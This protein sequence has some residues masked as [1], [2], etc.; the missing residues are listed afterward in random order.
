MLHLLLWTLYGHLEEATQQPQQFAA[1]AQ[2][3][4]PKALSQPWLFQPACTELFTITNLSDLYM[5]LQPLPPWPEE[6]HVPWWPNRW[7]VIGANTVFHLH[8][9]LHQ[10]WCRH[11][12]HTPFLVVYTGWLAHFVSQPG[13]TPG[14]PSD[15]ANLSSVKAS[16]EWPF[17]AYFWPTF[18]LHH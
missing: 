12:C 2:L 3:W 8:K 13:D 5:S 9:G 10:D 14:L 6:E 16:L 11:T 7:P 18:D 1:K 4:F 15:I 17:L